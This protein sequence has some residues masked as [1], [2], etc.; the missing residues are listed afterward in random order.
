V[1]LTSDA[2]LFYKRDATGLPRLR[3]AHP[4]SK[5]RT[6]ELVVPLL[7]AL[8]V[9]KRDAGRFTLAARVDLVGKSSVGTEERV[10]R[11]SEVLPGFSVAYQF[12][13]VHFADADGD[14][15]TD[16]IVALEDRAA[17]FRQ[18]P[19]LRFDAAPSWERDFAVRSAGERAK[20]FQSAR[21]TVGDFDG[22]GLA[23]IVVAKVVGR[24]ITSAATTH[25]L[26]LGRRGGGWPSAPDQTLKIDGLGGSDAAEPIDLT[27]DGHP[28]LIVPTIN[29]GVWA[30]IRVLT[31]KTLTVVFQVFP[32]TPQRRFSDKPFAQRELKFKVSF[33][34]DS[35][36]PAL[37][38]HGDFNGDR[39]PDLAFGS[40]EDE[41][42]I[43]PGLAPGAGGAG[44][45][46]KEPVER[47]AVDSRARLLAVDLDGKGKDDIVLYYPQTLGHKS[48]IVVLAN[49]GPW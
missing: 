8:A 44:L 13:D 27:G 1:P 10:S 12:P 16:I 20:A 38:I 33:A 24:G 31:T 46:T 9:Y 17:V 48:D 3:L 39:R 15:L 2:T 49:H 41:L 42:A 22:D 47:V 35:D 36:L 14:G 4:L 21:I 43:Y 6:P 29:M 11:T 30:I 19:G 5:S 7:G 37:E 45:V 25:F 26:Y 34:G 23:D 32:W 40:R 18:H 28:D